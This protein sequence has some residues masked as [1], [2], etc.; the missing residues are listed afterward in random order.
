[1]GK[2]KQ[3]VEDTEFDA[4]I[5]AAKVEFDREFTTIRKMLS[6]ADITD[7]AG[8]KTQRR[9]YARVAAESEK[10]LREAQLRY[11]AAEKAA[12]DKRDSQ[13]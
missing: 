10:R 7:P 4:A 8:R 13:L 9:H 6:D 2:Q 11:K 12:K 1:M 3:R 5:N